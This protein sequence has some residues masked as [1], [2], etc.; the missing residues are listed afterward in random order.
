MHP[1]HYNLPADDPGTWHGRTAH[2]DAIARLATPMLLC[3]SNP[4][5]KTNRNSQ[6]PSY[7]AIGGA[8]VTPHQYW[9]CSNGDGHGAGERHLCYNGVFATPWGPPAHYPKGPGSACPTYANW[10]NIP[11]H[12]RGLPLRRITDG[13]SN[14]M[15]FGEQSK[16]G[17]D[18][19]GV[20]CQCK[21]EGMWQLGA[22]NWVKVNVPLGTLI[23]PGNQLSGFRSSHGVGA[24]FARADGS[25]AWLEESIEFDLYRILMR[26]DS[27]STLK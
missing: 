24:Q 5:P 12:Q 7:A 21:N 15:M 3:P 4:M 27:G 10:V 16:W 11:F 2:K 20:Q 6:S 8:T 9:E 13:L 25:V 18:G 22:S 17:L 14:V 26:R 19:S 1:S 23:S